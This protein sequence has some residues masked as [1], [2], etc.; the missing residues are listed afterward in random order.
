MKHDIDAFHDISDEFGIAH[1]AFD[2]RQL[3]GGSGGFEILPPSSGEIV[4]DDDLLVSLKD[5]SIGDVGPNQ[6]GA[7]CN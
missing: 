5:Q 4:K 7:T 3:S 2:E 6:S 1:V